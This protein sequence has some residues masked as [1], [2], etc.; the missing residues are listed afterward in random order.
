MAADPGEGGEEG[1]DLVILPISGGRFPIQLAGLYQLT[2]LGFRPP[3]VLASS[4][5]TVASYTACAANWSPAGIVRVARSLDAQYFI[6]SWFS[7]GLDIFHSALAGFFYGAIY[8][9]SERSIQFFETYFTPET[10]TQTEV[11]V[12]A[13]NYHTG[14][15]CLFSNRAKSGSIIQGEHFNPRIFKCE[16]L[17]Y[18]AGSLEGI[19]NASMA[20]SSVPLMVEPRKIGDGHYIDCG[21]KFASPLTPMKDE[22]EALGKRG[23]LHLFYISG[24]DVEADTT[25]EEIEN[26]VNIFTGTWAVTEHLVRGFI[27]HD[28]QSAYEV[29][30]SDCRAPPHYAEFDICKLATVM[31]RYRRSESSLVEIYP[32]LSCKL[33]GLA[34]F[35][36]EDVVGC[37]EYAR[38]RLGIRVWWNGNEDL[39]C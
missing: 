8:K 27:I 37:L 19:M 9:A 23:P 29:V 4:G 12:G 18:L 25:P 28:R 33:L 32:K 17:R 16:P 24:H 11:W 21:A 5:G 15:A 20:S 3:L 7:S 6:Q 35:T 14:A 26:H 34:D 22:I 13:I 38:G 36:G 2:R 31:E 39:F 30:K 10:I 1:L